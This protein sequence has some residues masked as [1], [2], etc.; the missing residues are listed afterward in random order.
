MKFE[1]KNIEHLI[2]SLKI[3]YKSWIIIIVSFLFINPLN[4]GGSLFTFI[5]MILI[6]HVVHYFA[7][8]KSAYPGNLVHLYHHDHNNWF[9]HFIQ[10]VLEFVALTS[11]ILVKYFCGTGIFYKYFSQFMD[12]WVIWFSYLFYTSVHNI[13]YSYFHVNKVHELHHKLKLQNI[14]PDVCDVLFGTKYDAQNDLENTDHYIPNI[15]VASL[16]VW[17]MKYFWNNSSNKEAYIVIF[18]VIF[19]VCSILLLETTVVLYIMNATRDP[20]IVPAKSC[21]NV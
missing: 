17:L 1:S 16:I 6:V 4:V 5:I 3:N 9:S 15:V 7:H 11:V 18:C 12:E 19:A 21:D 20:Y 14:G 8:C 2:D 13:N 10:I